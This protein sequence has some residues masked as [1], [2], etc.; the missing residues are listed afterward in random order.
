MISHHKSI[1]T[2]L[3]SCYHKTFP[4]NWPINGWVHAK[5]R[6]PIY[7][8]IDILRAIVANNL[9]KYQYFSM[10]PSLFDKNQQI[11]H[12]LQT[13]LCQYQ[14]QQPQLYWSLPPLSFP[15]NL[16][17][18]KRK[19]LIISSV[20]RCIFQ[21]KKLTQKISCYPEFTSFK[22]FSSKHCSVLLNI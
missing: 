20:T 12:S 4:P 11:T 15:T 6:M 9:V 14:S 5:K 13:T 18:I 8:I 17:I 21:T 3:L 7:G 19:C 1:D 22:D 2:C 10:R 16:R